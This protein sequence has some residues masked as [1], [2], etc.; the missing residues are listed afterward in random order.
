MSDAQDGKNAKRARALAQS[1]TADESTG[2]WDPAQLQFMVDQGLSVPTGARFRAPTSATELA[3]WGFSGG[4]AGPDPMIGLQQWLDKSGVSLQDFQ[5]KTGGLPLT[6][7][8]DGTA[9]YDPSA[10]RQ[11]FS[12]LN[13]DDGTFHKIA[14][15]MFAALTGAGLAGVGTAGATGAGM[16]G[17]G[18]AAELASVGATGGSMLGGGAST[19][20]GLGGLLGI[21]GTGNVL[22]D[23]LIST[24]IN[25]VGSRVANEVVPGSGALVGLLG[26]GLDKIGS[27]IGSIASG[28]SNAASS[29]GD[30]LTNLVSGGSD[31]INWDLMKEVGSFTGDATQGW[32][33]YATNT[34]N[35][36][37]A[38]SGDGTNWSVPDTVTNP[39]EVNFADS[40]NPVQTLPEGPVNPVNTNLTTGGMNTIDEMISSLTSG[41]AQTVGSVGAGVAAGA[42]GLGSIAELLSTVPSAGAAS[43]GLTLAQQIA[44]LFNP[45]GGSGSTGTGGMNLT[46]VGTSA[47]QMFLSKYLADK[48]DTLAR[49]LSDRADPFGSTNV[50][51]LRAD[52]QNEYKTQY[53]GGP[54]QWMESTYK[55]FAEANTDMALRK[56]AVSKG[57]SPSLNPGAL[58]DVV[59][60][61]TTTGYNDYMKGRTQVAG[62]AGAGFNPANAASLYGQQSANAIGQIGNMGG[63]LGSGISYATGGNGSQAGDNTVNVIKKLSGALSGLT[64]PV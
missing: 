44:K 59:K 64:S 29:I 16:V 31:G 58:A 2:L 41:G 34:G 52:A 30:T 45:G 15:L 9:T 12:Y 61:T 63:A 27:S 47:A 26:G 17:G 56:M 60:Y 3:S 7:N 46:G 62:E 22:V 11:S 20:G 23:K 49:D 39:G 50:K 38:V 4:G 1:Y 14:P 42:E 40:F 43:T 28:V 35:A 33:N 57:M 37:D 25:Q 5:A 19:I 18:G 55:P 6:F 32:D 10:Q 24:A 48:Y 53:S 36:L 21:E 51:G 54:A 8:D 13:P